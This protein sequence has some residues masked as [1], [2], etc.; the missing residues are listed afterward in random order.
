MNTYQ[1]KTSN[2]ELIVTILGINHTG[3]VFLLAILEILTILRQYQSVLTLY[4]GLPYTAPT[5]NIIQLSI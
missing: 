4:V 5:A 3:S 2:L 1:N